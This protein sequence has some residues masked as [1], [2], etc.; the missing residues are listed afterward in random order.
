MRGVNNK[1]Q[2]YWPN[3]LAGIGLGLILILAYYVAGR[4]LGGSGAVTRIT[5]G[6]M[7]LVAPE[8]TQNLSYFD[9]YFS[10]GS[11]IINDWLVFQVIGVFLGGVFGALTA[12][13][14]GKSVDKGERLSDSQRFMFA[15]L[16]GAIMGWGARLARGCTSGQALSG[17]ATLALGS[18]AFIA[19]LFIGGF[20]TALFA[21][22][23]W[24]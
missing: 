16:G 6:A 20:I 23:L 22:K 2:D 15:L 4:G 11:L 24:Y 9:R 14:F 13:R 19:A 10:G 21:K 12:G 18:W 3:I 7:N 5:A 17:G 8:H 1:K